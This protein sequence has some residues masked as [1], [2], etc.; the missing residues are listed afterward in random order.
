MMKVLVA[1]ILISLSLS[2][3]RLA[4]AL[5]L[6]VFSALIVG[7]AAGVDRRIEKGVIPVLDVLQSVPILGFFPIAIYFLA[8]S[9]PII[10]LEL[11]SIFLIFTCT[12]WNIAFGVYEAV[13]AVPTSV[14]DVLELSNLGWAAR[15]SK[16]YIPA[17]IPRIADQL[18]ASLANAFYFL[19]ASE[20]LAL[21]SEELALSGIGSL[22]LGAI[23]KGDI[24][25]AALSLAAVVLSIS[26]VYL[27]VINPISSYA[28]KYRFDITQPPARPPRIVLPHILPTIR[29]HLFQP[30]TR[31][32]ITAQR[33]LPTALVNVRYVSWGAIRI[34]AF[35]SL[36]AGLI[37][38]VARVYAELPDVQ[39]TVI[40]IL[41]A[42]ASLGVIPMLEAVGFS[43]MRVAICISLN[44]AISLI[45]VY[46]LV[47]KAG[48]LRDAIL[49]LLQIVASLPAPLVFPLVA[50]LFEANPLSREAGAI[51]LMSLGTFWYILYSTL[52]GFTKV[53]TEYLE[54]A[55][56]YKL[57]GLKK[58][59]YIYLP[60]AVP[61]IVTGLLT[62]T[63]GAWN[64]IIIAERLGREG[65]IFAVTTPGLGK[66]MAEFA[67]RGDLYALAYT[68]IVMTLVIVALNRILWRRLYDYAIKALR[69]H[70]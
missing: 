21:G 10:G 51:L 37:L 66:I 2:W 25:T 41:A 9:I 54:L 34:L 12:F 45:I 18:P 65:G 11:A 3:L 58:L 24:Y 60:F 19:A 15:L 30:I 31:F 67:E 36:I 52:G 47:E 39:A 50:P 68:V 32:S 44:F 1:E 53:H 46:G 14:L 38:L 35:I 22:I 27:F 16:V 64:T 28:N 23:A 70:E 62:A 8:T 26:A 43:M 13:R 63:G 49:P 61:S 57:S 56:L 69:I 20:I 42:A 7:I 4:V 40:G 48:R 33:I 5:A 6:S 59:R 17:S 29:L 55:E